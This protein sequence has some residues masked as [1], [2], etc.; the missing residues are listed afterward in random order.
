MTQFLVKYIAMGAEFILLVDAP[1][2]IDAARKVAAAAPTVTSRTV[3]HVIK[4]PTDIKSG[5]TFNH[6]SELSPYITTADMKPYKR[7]YVDLTTTDDP[8]E[9]VW[10]RDLE[11]EVDLQSLRSLFHVFAVEDR[12]TQNI[13]QWTPFEE[14]AM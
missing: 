9:E 10:V 1:N 6:S 11:N 2:R 7:V 8:V 5:I 3:T 12:N 14:V 4:A 13:T